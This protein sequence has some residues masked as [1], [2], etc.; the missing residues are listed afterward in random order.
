ME[1]EDGLTGTTSHYDFGARIYDSRVGRFLSTDFLAKKYPQYSSYNFAGNSPIIAIDVAGD[2]I[3]V[4]IGDVERGRSGQLQVINE[5]HVTIK[6]LDVSK[7]GYTDAEHREIAASIQGELNSELNYTQSANFN[8]PK[9]G[10]PEDGV[11]RYKAKVNVEYVTSMS[12]VGTGDH[13]LVLVDDVTFNEPLGGITSSTLGVATRPGKIAY[14]QT[15][16]NVFSK[17]SVADAVKTAIH[18]LGHSFGLKH[19]WEDGLPETGGKTSENHMSYG[20]KRTEFTPS[21]V[22]EIIQN[23]AESNE[24]KNFEEVD[25]DNSTSWKSTNEKPYKGSVKKGDKIPKTIKN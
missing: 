13:L 19:S 5:L 2:S 4:V 11:M 16:P 14:V 1:K 9:T 24:G 3:W 6:V 17:S 21:Q 8:D 10:K 15:Y 25:K 20:N 12:D 22:L 23:R 18:E 7:R